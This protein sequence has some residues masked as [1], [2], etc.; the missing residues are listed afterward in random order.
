MAGILFLF[1]QQYKHHKL[2]WLHAR[3]VGLRPA[4]HELAARRAARRRRRCPALFEDHASGAK[5]DRTGWG[6]LRKRKKSYAKSGPPKIP[7]CLELYGNLPYDCVRRTKSCP[8][9]PLPPVSKPE[10]PPISIPSSSVPLN[11]KPAP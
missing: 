2:G 8:S 4:E 3:V 9:P 6:R 11:C 10:S 5:D 7:P 1:R